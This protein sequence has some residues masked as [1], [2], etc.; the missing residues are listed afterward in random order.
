MELSA[1]PTIRCLIAVAAA[2]AI[3]LA[4][5][6]CGDEQKPKLTVT[7]VPPPAAPQDEAKPAPG[8]PAAGN[9]QASNDQALAV[10]V[11]SALAAAPGLNS[12]RID[13]T[14]RDGS[15]TLFG[16]AESRQQQEAA[17]KVAAAVAG[18]KSVDNKLALVAGS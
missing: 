1:G 3:A 9:V 4:V 16:T 6:G 7:S 12:H 8:K 10:R 14:V 2:S 15:V 11:R 5:S 17:A 13:V 18:V